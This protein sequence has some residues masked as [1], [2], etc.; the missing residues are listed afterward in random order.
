VCVC[1]CLGLSVCANA[2]IYDARASLSHSSP[3]CPS[4]SDFLLAC[5]F[6]T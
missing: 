1:V 4:E 3:R 6:Q 5:C 2:G